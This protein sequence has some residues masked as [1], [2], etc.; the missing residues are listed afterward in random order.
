MKLKKRKTK[1][2]VVHQEKCLNC[3]HPF[4][5]KEKFCPECGQANKGDKITFYNFIHEIFNG[6]FSFDAKFWRTII[7][8]L[9]KPGKVSR[10]Y[11]DGKRN[12]YSNPF[13]FYFTVSILFFLIMSISNGVEKFN[14]LNKKSSKKTT[15]VLN[16]KKKDINID[17]LKNAVNKTLDNPF[18][19]IDSTKRAKILNDI[20]KE[21]RDTTKSKDFGRISFGY[22]KL[23]KFIDFQKK[24]PY[25]SSDEAL[26]SLGFEKNLRNRFLYDRGKLANTVVRSKEGRDKFFSELLSY[27]SASLFVFLPLFTLFL[28]FFYIRRKYTYVDHLIFVFHTQTVFFMLL[29]I[30]YLIELFG[31]STEQWVYLLLF[32]LY[33]FIAM[34]TFY[35]QGYFKTFIKFIMLNIAYMILGGIGIFIVALFS[36][37]VY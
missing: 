22:D 16:V 9:T 33:L 17:S 3:G 21:A 2:V 35:K 4:L 11:V 25:I 32:L 36:F 18:I 1:K 19:P 37:A 34:K 27:A 14:S 28:K 15:S 7:P 6:F 24:N 20:E 10:D 12:R 8:L 23:D 5:N 30:F 31:F 29:S 13:R 26:D